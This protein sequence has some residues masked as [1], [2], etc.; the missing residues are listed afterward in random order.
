MNVYQIHVV[1]IHSA[2]TA[3]MISF[4]NA[5]QL[6]PAKMQREIP[7]MIVQIFV[8]I[9]GRAVAVL[10]VEKVLRVMFIL[11]VRFHQKNIVKNITMI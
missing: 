4:A 9:K 5:S 6:I 1:L 11:L 2:L 10:E 8:M 7:S 3:L